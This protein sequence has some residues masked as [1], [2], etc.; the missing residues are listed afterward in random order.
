MSDPTEAEKNW[1][2]RKVAAIFVGILGFIFGF[3]GA[4]VIGAHRTIMT[5]QSRISS[6][7]SRTEEASSQTEE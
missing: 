5:S 2:F 3:L 4:C 1:K 7:S 6:A